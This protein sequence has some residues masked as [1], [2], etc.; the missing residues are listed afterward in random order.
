MM[1]QLSRCDM[2]DMAAYDP[3]S[4]HWVANYLLS[5]AFRGRYPDPYRQIALAY[6]R[7]SEAAFREHAA[8]RDELLLYVEAPDQRIRNY[9]QCL[10]HIEQLVTQLYQ[11]YML[12][13]RLLAKAQ[14]F[15]RDD[16][17]E[18]ARLNVL[19]NF[20]KHADE[21]LLD[22]LHPEDGAVPV[23]LANEGVS[24]TKATVTF[25]ELADMLKD[26]ANGANR[27]SDPVAVRGEREG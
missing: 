1:S 23:W 27:F 22:G 9:F 15:S 11:A 3:Q 14:L 10:Y 4:G 18:L 7:R 17:S 20:V 24:C 13:R 16:G 19:Y 2:P 25:A 5:S 12:L 26:V 21:K 8:A 6:M